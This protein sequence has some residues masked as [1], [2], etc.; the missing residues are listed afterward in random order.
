MPNQSNNK[1]EIKQLKK[2]YIY[3]AV[4]VLCLLVFIY[5]VSSIPSAQETFRSFIPRQQE[6]HDEASISDNQGGETVIM[7][8]DENKEK[9][10]TQIE[11]FT[12]DISSPT[13][14]SHPDTIAL[15][16]KHY[17]IFERNIL[18]P[19]DSESWIQYDIP[20]KNNYSAIS[21]FYQLG[22]V[23]SKWTQKATIHKVA[24]SDKDCYALADKIVNGLIVSY[25]N[26]MEVNG[27]K[28]TKDNLSVNYVKKNPTNTELYWEHKGIVGT[29]DE[30]QFLRVFISEYSGEMYLVTY[31]IKG[32]LSDLDDSAIIGS[33]KVIESVQQLKE[34]G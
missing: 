10:I 29:T 6:H 31:T 19:F 28:L 15:S 9:K 26:Q 25:S 2:I 7:Q 27:E 5:V 17:F 32:T 13:P 1:E 23:P 33:L 11:D 4:A 34:K 14:T 21:E 3:G 16:G 18:M 12:N 20:A 22:E 24:M 8:Q 30:V